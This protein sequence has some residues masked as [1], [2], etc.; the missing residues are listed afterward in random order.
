MNQVGHG[1]LEPNPVSLP[2]KK[3]SFGALFYIL[4]LVAHA[5]NAIIA[6]LSIFFL[7]F[8]GVGIGTTG[9]F[10]KAFGVLIS[11]FSTAPFVLFSLS[12]LVLLSDSKPW[13]RK[14]A[15]I[16]LPFGCV[17]TLGSVF[18]IPGFCAI[19]LTLKICF[20]ASNETGETIEHIGPPRILS[21]ALREENLSPP[22]EF[23]LGKGFNVQY[24]IDAR[25]SKRYVKRRF[26]AESNHPHESAKDDPIS[27]KSNSK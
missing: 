17:S 9:G 13:A 18:P 16:A 15:W 3:S 4:F 12:A 27:K 10:D 20:G 19:L 7:L 26:E 24:E 5:S 25:D 23:R 14:L 6:F 11:I 2:L 1:A 8:T 21:R 22:A